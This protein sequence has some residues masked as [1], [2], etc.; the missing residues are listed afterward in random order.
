[1]I[2]EVT[3]DLI[4]LAKT[5]VFDIIAHG[6]NCFCRQ[7]RGLAPQ[8]TQ[9]FGTDNFPLE[10]DEFEGDAD[11]LGRIDCQLSRISDHKS[12]WVV[13]MY[14]QYHWKEPGP[15]GIPLDY[16]ALRLCL[17]KLAMENK[18]ETDTIGLPLIGCGLAGGDLHT[19]KQIMGEEL[20]GKN[21]T[22]VY[23]E[24]HHKKIPNL[25]L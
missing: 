19:V 23:F 1:M 6:C 4:A 20:G 21:V 22:L 12:I 2:T 9:V 5:G 3:G 25:V 8:M 17:R 7:K 18:I 11:K 13:N 16:D 14:T 10:A 24:E 15:Y